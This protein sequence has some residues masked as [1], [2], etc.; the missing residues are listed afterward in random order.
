MRDDNFLVLLLTHVLMLLDQ[1]KY[2]GF[3]FQVSDKGDGEMRV[4]VGVILAVRPLRCLETVL[5]FS[6]EA[7]SSEIRMRGE[8]ETVSRYAEKC[9]RMLDAEFPG[10][11]RNDRHDLSTDKG[12]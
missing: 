10:L 2:G 12:A 4:E 1:N 8:D 6:H 5:V 11:R 7:L 3:M 9:V